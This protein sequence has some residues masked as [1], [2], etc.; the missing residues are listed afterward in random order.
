MFQAFIVYVLVNVGAFLWLTWPYLVKL[1][2][3]VPNL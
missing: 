2:V 1:G 3:P